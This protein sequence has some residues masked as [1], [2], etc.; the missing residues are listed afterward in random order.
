MNSDSTVVSRS[1][2]INS[3]Y[4]SMEQMEVRP[5]TETPFNDALGGSDCMIINDN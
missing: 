1:F 5:N 3:L 2:M 4:G